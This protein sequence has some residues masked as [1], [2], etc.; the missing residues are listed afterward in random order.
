MGLFSSEPK[1]V[2]ALREAFQRIKK[3]QLGEEIGARDDFLMAYSH[4]KTEGKVKI[5]QDLNLAYKT[6][7]EQKIAADL[8]RA[9]FEDS[10][11]NYH[12][13]KDAYKTAR[14]FGF[15]IDPGVEEKL[16]VAAKLY[17]DK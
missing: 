4:L 8:E 1:E 12:S 7:V 14:A 16:R 6:V 2:K 13:A 15:E 17:E 5:P 3:A 10:K 11:A 9:G